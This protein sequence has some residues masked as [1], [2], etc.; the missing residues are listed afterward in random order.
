MEA[1]A[2]EGTRGLGR[3]SQEGEGGLRA[4]ALLVPCWLRR[5]LPGNLDFR[6]GPWVD[7]MLNLSPRSWFPP[8]LGFCARGTTWLEP[9]ENRRSSEHAWLSGVGGRAVASLPPT[10][11]VGLLQGGGQDCRKRHSGSQ[12]DS[13]SSWCSLSCPLPSMTKSVF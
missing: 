6:S 10:A 4:L 12:L 5:R 11:A 8:P 7:G 9:E 3:T 2:Q 1:R 13:K